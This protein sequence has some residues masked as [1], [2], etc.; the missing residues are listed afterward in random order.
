MS[1]KYYLLLAILLWNLVV[2]IMYA[3]DKQRARKGAWRI[4]ERALILGALCAGGLGA[5]AGMYLLRHKTRHLQFRI[6]IPIAVVLTAA[7]MI[8]IILYI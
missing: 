8:L 6:L 4:S 7:V 3:A 1:I 5:A 2:F